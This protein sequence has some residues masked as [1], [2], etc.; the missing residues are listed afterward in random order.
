MYYFFSWYVVGGAC[1]AL[2]GYVAYSVLKFFWDNRQQ[3][4]QTLAE[5]TGW[6]VFG[7]LILIGIGLGAIIIIALVIA[8]AHYIPTI[9]IWI[10]LAVFLAVY[11][12]NVMSNRARMRQEKR[13]AQDLA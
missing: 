11:L 1:L 2:L 10:F 13:R 5:A 3:I 6:L 7:S 12:A 8:G 4:G 9:A